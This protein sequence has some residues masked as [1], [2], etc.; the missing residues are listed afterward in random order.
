MMQTKSRRLTILNEEWD[1]LAGI[2]REIHRIEKDEGKMTNNGL[3]GLLLLMEA[4]P[5]FF[6]VVGRVLLSRPPRLGE[7]L[8]SFRMGSA[9]RDEAHWQ[10]AQKCYGQ[11]L[12]RTMPILMIA[13]AMTCMLLQRASA[14]SDSATIAAVIALFVEVLSV[15]ACH[16]VTIRRL[17]RQFR[18]L[19]DATKDGK[20]K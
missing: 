19:S 6:L 7:G 20:D 3:W 2:Y 18:S 12:T 13:S 4:L 5:V 14:A 16:A 15:I 11:Q 17:E 8:V 1:C 10:F 9:R